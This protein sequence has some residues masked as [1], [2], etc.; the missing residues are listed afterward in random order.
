LTEAV[1]SALEDVEGSFAVLC[2][3]ADDPGLVVGARRGSPLV[4][5]HTADTG[6]AA[7]D[8]PALGPRIAELYVPADDQVVEVR[9]GMVRVAAP[10]GGVLRPER[11]GVGWDASATERGDWP[12]FTLKEIHEQPRALAATLGGRR[13]GDSRISASA[14]G[15]G[16][17]PSRL[18]RIVMLGCGTSLNAGLASRPA[19]ESWARVSV[20]CESASEFRYRDVVLDEATL[21]IGVTQ[22]GETVDTIYA[23]REARRQGAPTL[24]VTNVAASAVTREVD[25]TLLTHAGPEIGVAATKTHV[26]QI[27]ALQALALSLASERVTLPAA[28]VSQLTDAL[29]E[30]PAGVEQVL[31]KA[32]ETLAVARSYAG[33]RDFLFL[34]RGS[35][36]AVACEGALKLKEIAYVR[37]EAYSGGEL[38]H[39][40]IALVEPGMV[41]VGV[42]GTGVLRTKMLSNIAEVQARGATVVLV[43]AEDD[44]EAA[45]L[46]EDVLAVPSPAPGAELLSPVLEIVALQL[47]A[48]G[49]AT[50]RGLD[51]DKPRNLAKTVT[52]E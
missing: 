4:V 42:V 26:A 45:E 39:G 38:K 20:E 29:R 6:L 31:A 5:G 49:V 25:A 9:A 52:V 33:S 46:A 21:V 24:G 1:E 8:M 51:V 19:F 17:E 41:V 14:A 48:Y 50:A 37:A 47:F 43:A 44:T 15:T 13:R 30:L 16:L 27:V 11:R 18:R 32:E 10:A 23:L 40:P 34:G 3:H 12:D 7:S 2:V 22:S 28:R 36:H 35:G